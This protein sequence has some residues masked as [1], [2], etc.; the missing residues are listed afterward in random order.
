MRSAD[1][2]KLGIQIAI[3]EVDASKIEAQLDRVFT[4]L[5][6]SLELIEPGN[7]PLTSTESDALMVTLPAIPLP[8]VEL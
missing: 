4:R 1:N 3:E 6:Q 5:A 7:V 2:A 8:K